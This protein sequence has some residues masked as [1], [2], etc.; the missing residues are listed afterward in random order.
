[1]TSQIKSCSQYL[2]VLFLFAMTLLACDDQQ[3]DRMVVKAD[4]EW[5]RGRNQTAIE[6]LKS[7]L[8]KVPSGLLAEKIIFRLGE[9]NYFTLNNSSRAL[10]YFQELLRLSPK[11]PLSYSAQK[12]IAEIVE[13][14]LKDLDQA[15]IENQKLIDD[16]N[17]PKDRGDYQ[18]RIASIYF[19]KQE[20]EQALV[21]LEILLEN[22]SES[23]WAEEAAF[24][25]ANILYTAN[26]CGE[27]RK[28]Y[29]WFVK[30]FPKSKYISEMDFVMASCLEEEGELNLAYDKFKSLEGSYRYP[31]L[32]KLKLEGIEERLRKKRGKR[33]KSPYIL[34]KKSKAK[35]I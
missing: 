8:E 5:I 20:S 31:S 13:F 29:D 33:K 19:K 35:K 14:E 32:L 6:I 23:P 11:S 4:E 12:Y 24:R 25:I 2:S 7:V 34:K 22:F 3:F 21:E 18:F 28:R 16:F 27:A 9:I 30:R 1:M 15:I 17:Y 26:R 10:Y